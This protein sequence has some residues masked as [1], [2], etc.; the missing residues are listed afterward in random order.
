MVPL[1]SV[2]IFFII[3]L[4]LGMIFLTRLNKCTQKWPHAHMYAKWKVIILICYD[5]NCRSS[6]IKT[7]FFTWMWVCIIWRLNV[8]INHCFD[9]SS[10]QL[11][12]LIL[13]YNLYSILSNAVNSFI[14]VTKTFVLE[15]DYLSFL[16]DKLF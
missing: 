5:F 12:F 2:G 4:I 9:S 16:Y 11:K 14:A 13:S 8:L 1:D 15:K 7:T 6:I 3:F 10:V